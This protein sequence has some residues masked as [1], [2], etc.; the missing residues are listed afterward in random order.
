M[1][2]QT[3][4]SLDALHALQ[5]QWEALYRRVDSASIFTSPTWVMN[6]LHA[7]GHMGSLRCIA[8]YEGET[9]HAVLPLLQVATR[10][11][12]VPV[13]ALIACTNAHSVRSV[14]LFAPEHATP[15]R[16]ALQQWLHT[17][18]EW[19][20]LLLDGC[21]NP[22]QGVVLPSLDREE[23]RHPWQ[24]SVLPI[25]GSWSQYLGGRSRDLRRN[26]R[27]TVEGLASHGTLKTRIDTVWSQQ[28]M[29]DWIAIDRSSWKA[30]DGETIDN[31]THTLHYY[32]RMLQEFSQQGQLL[33]M[34]ILCDETPIS[35]VICV[36]D[37]GV[38]YTLKTASRKDF[39]S[40][41]LSPG[42]LAM[43]E[44]LEYIWN[45]AHAHTV[46][47]VSKQSYT[48]R[49]S[50]ASQ[51]FERRSLFSGTWRARIARVLE[52]Y[53]TRHHLSPTA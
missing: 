33:A 3:L 13:R 21:D 43:S 37:K 52:H 31:D 50:M 45:Q 18:G 11:R 28:L 17:Q 2:V 25:E 16:D 39:C 51:T 38:F 42:L 32:T 30:S 7:F 20:L 53:A 15:V 14:L 12:K 19:D 10:W 41:S 26:I 44:L 35:N 1:R 27:R 5:P 34:T 29:D 23:P 8:L 40:A 4:S 24:H 6:W 47:F 46:D 48:E 9:L 22:L 36:H 49:W